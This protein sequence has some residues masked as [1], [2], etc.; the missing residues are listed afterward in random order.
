LA[1]KEASRVALADLRATLGVVRSD[2]RSPAANLDRLPELVD[3]ATSAG[4][5][6]RQHGTPGEI[7]A[8]VSFAA[9]RIVQESLTN[10]I[11]HARDADTVVVE[12]EPADSELTLV[13]TD[14]GTAPGVGVGNGLRGMR[15]RAEALGGSLVAGPAARG[16]QVRAVLPL[17]GEPS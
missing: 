16:F 9:Y 7:P 5:T 15:E 17:R 10:T 2:D 1:I 14:N 8:H 12:F 6:V 3:A 4:L 11:R 13:V